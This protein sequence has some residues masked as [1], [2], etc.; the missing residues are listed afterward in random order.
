MRKLLFIPVLLLCTLFISAQTTKSTEHVQQVWAGY[1]NQT[2]LSDKWGFWAEAQLRTKEEFFTNLSQAVGRAGITYYFN[3]DTRLTAGYAFINFY[4]GDNHKNISQPEHRPWQQ[5]Q[6]FT[7]YQK[8]RLMQWFRLEERYRHKILND[9]EL[10]P[11]YNFNFRIRYNF[12][13]QVPLS[14]KRFQPKTL[15][16]VL[17]NEVHIN[18]GQQIVYNYFDQNRFFLGFNYHV[19]KH[20]QL[21]FGWMNIFQ[22]LPAGNKYRSNNVARV[23][24]FHNLDLRKQ[25]AK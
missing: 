23:F 7:K 3:D 25:R 22:Q 13:A 24:F 2:R 8:L 9:N 4:P 5:I 1:F 16:F 18:F 12:F 19:N 20:D 21:Q 14:K 10:A 15:S 6:W 17:N 11:G